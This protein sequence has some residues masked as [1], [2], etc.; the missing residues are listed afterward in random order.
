MKLR[1]MIPILCLL[2]YSL[3][4]PV[5]TAA[6]A[7]PIAQ[8]ALENTG[9]TLPWKLVTSTPG[10]YVVDLPG[11][12]AE[13]ISTSPLLERN[14]QWHMSS[15]TIPAVD[16]KDLFE[17][18]LVAY[19]DV[20]RS[21]RYNFSQKQLL[22]AATTSVVNDIKDD[23]LSTT[24]TV[25]EVAFQGLPSRLLT[26]RGLGQYFVATLSLTGDRLYLLLAIDNDQANFERF[27]NS[28]SLV[29]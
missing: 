6:E 4:S 27:F 1:L 14:L 15:V 7:P 22:D 11:T 5:K 28:L 18:Y 23:Q 25:E 13:Q 2:G 29:P 20:P 19:A 9:Q 17:Y 16:D 12:P 8:S 10:K 24:L 21:L 3:L 26:A